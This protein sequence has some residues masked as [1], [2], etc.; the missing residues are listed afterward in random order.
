MR[1]RDL[2]RRLD[3]RVSEL[4]QQQRDIEAELRVIANLR[5]EVSDAASPKKRRRALAT[6]GNG[7]VVQPDPGATA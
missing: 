7:A 4:L 6:A 2:N 3:S 5:G 1:T